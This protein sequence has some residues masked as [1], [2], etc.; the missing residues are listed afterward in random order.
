M[1]LVGVWSWC[2]PLCRSTLPGESAGRDIRAPWAVSSPAYGIFGAKAKRQPGWLVSSDT[3]CK[4]KKPPDTNVL[5]RPQS[6]E[7]RGP[8]WRPGGGSGPERSLL[9]DS[10][11]SWPLPRGALQCF[12]LPGC[13][14]N[15]PPC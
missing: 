15:L 3:P 9:M 2:D 5:E 13:V 6:G 11:H 7:V 14:G 4:E 12:L 1:V 8:W 10:Q